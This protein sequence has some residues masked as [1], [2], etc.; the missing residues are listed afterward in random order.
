MLIGQDPFDIDQLT[1]QM[2]WRVSY[3]GGYHG[4][5][6]HGVTGVEVALWDLT[7]KVAW[8]ACAQNLERRSLHR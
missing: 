2:M 8:H 5:P 7:G 1:T 6:L 4:P 3:L